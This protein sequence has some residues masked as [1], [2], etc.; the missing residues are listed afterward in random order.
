LKHNSKREQ[1]SFNYIA[2]KEKLKFGYIQGDS[3]NNKYFTHMGRHKG[4]K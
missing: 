4:N 2:W 1:L 3:R